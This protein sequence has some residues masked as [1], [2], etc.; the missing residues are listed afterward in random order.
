MMHAMFKLNDITYNLISFLICVTT[1][2][3]CSHVEL[4]FSDGTVLTTEPVKGVHFVDGHKNRTYN[5]YYWSAVPLP[6]ITPEQEN[7]IYQFGQQLVKEEC[8][9]DYC[10]AILGGLF[11][12]QMPNAYFCSE[13]VAAALSEYTEG[14]NPM[15]WISPNGMWKF[16]SNYLWKNY[17]E[18]NPIL[19]SN[20]R[21]LSE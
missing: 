12:C 17:P 5:P 6:W 1:W 16:L 2:S 20:S 18:Y 14:L 19:L 10:G 11:A 3:K 21:Y 13:L 8:G 7:K 15:K 4:C 9:Y